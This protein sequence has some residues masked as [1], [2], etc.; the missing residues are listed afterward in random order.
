MFEIPIYDDS[1]ERESN[2]SCRTGD[3]K[4]V[5]ISKAGGGGGGGGFSPQVLQGIIGMFVYN[6]HNYISLPVI[7]HTHIII[8]K[9]GHFNRLGVCM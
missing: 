8:N 4:C 3:N 6:W 7:I 1:I 5:P 9:N 2:I